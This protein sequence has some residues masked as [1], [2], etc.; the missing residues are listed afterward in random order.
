MIRDSVK[1][2]VDKHFVAGN[3]CG[4]PLKIFVKKQYFVPCFPQMKRKT[5]YESCNSI[6]KLLFSG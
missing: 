1:M 4:L 6:Y 3:K 2:T 5:E